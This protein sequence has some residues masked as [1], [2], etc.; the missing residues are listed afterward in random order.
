M[1]I[2]AGRV[3]AGARRRF[4]FLLRCVTGIILAVV[5]VSEN[6]AGGRSADRACRSA[7]LLIVV[8]A[9]AA[10]C[11]RELS[12]LKVTPIKAANPAA[13]DEYLLSHRPDLD[14]LRLRGPFFVRAL[15]NVLVGHSF[16][17]GC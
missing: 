14:T 4:R 6:R 8:V 3:A 15:K 10:G 9:L 5:D 7:L 12:T 1:P 13:L 2:G 11:S 17:Y 16:G